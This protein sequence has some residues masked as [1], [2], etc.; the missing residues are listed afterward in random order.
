MIWRA[1]VAAAAAT[2]LVTP[3]FAVGNVA[4][5]DYQR[6]LQEAP[7]VK[8]SSDLLKQEYT[9]GAKAI[10]RQRKRVAKLT[11]IEEALGPGTNDLER[12][13]AAE[14]LQ[15][16]Q[17]KLDK[18]QNEYSSGLAMQRRQSR[19]NFQNIVEA[20]IRKYVKTHGFTLVVNSGDVIYTGA[21]TDITGK[22]LAILKRQYR[23]AQAEAKKGKQGQ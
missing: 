16:A 22:I 4:S 2:L 13:S 8:G 20:D 17:K 23:E 14:N 10:E 12:S 9:P 15:N 3:A 1:L 21:A 18:L 19:A 5:L 6:L 11:K 7:Q